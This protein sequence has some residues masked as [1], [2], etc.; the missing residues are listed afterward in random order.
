MPY[1]DGAAREALA[2]GAP[3]RTPGELNYVITR[4]INDYVKAQGL[5]YTVLNDVMGVLH[6]VE[7]CVRDRRRPLG[8]PPCNADELTHVI[9]RLLGEYM[10]V[11]ASTSPTDE[12]DTATEI[13]VDGVLSSVM[14]EFYRRLVVPY[15]DRKREENGEVYD[16][17]LLCRAHGL[18]PG[19]TYDLKQTPGNPWGFKTMPVCERCFGAADTPNHQRQHWGLPPIPVVGEPIPPTGGKLKVYL[20]GGFYSDWRERLV[21]ELPIDGYD[22]FSRTPQ[23]ATFLFVQ[24]DLEAITES[25]LVIAYFPGGYAPTGMAAEIGWAVAHQV[26]V[27][28]IDETDAPDLFLVGCSKRFFPSLGAL[29]RWWKDREERERPIL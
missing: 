8:H 20:A 22:P 4:I 11:K 6:G 2:A 23:W 7:P 29:V 28:Y 15:E 18:G 21:K 10:K 16:L 1:I 19:S 24:G 27:F 13:A 17:E 3:S 25:D 26:P 12:R 5:S 9:G 14:A